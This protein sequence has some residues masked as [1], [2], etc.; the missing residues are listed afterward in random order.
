MTAMHR[1]EETFYCPTRGAIFKFADMLHF[2]D[3]DGVKLHDAQPAYAC[4]VA[5]MV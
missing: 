2:G 4:R 1:L 3:G 5:R